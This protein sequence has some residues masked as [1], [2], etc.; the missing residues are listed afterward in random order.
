MCGRSERRGERG[1]HVGEERAA[2]LQVRAHEGAPVRLRDAGHLPGVREAVVEF[3][4]AVE[5]DGDAERIEAPR[6]AEDGAGEGE[7]GEHEERPRVHGPR[8]VHDRHESW[9]RE[10][11][12]PAANADAQAASMVRWMRKRSAVARRC[13]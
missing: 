13:R 3:V 2:A 5:L 4:R 12:Q 7:R 9:G 1:A 10:R 11:A 8:A 6:R